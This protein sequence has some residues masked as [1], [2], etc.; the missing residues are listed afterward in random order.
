VVFVLYN[1]NLSE[2]CV[3]PLKMLFIGNSATYVND[4]PGTLVRLARRAGYSLEA[5][6]IVKG[7]ATLS[8][9]AD[10]DT[11]HGESVLRAIRGTYDIIW[12]QDNGNCV[13]CEEKRQDSLEACRVLGSLIRDAG[14][15][16]GI[17]LRPPYGYEKWGIS[18]FEQCKEY[19]LHFL[20][21]AEELQ[22]LNAFVNRAFAF[23]IRDTEYD[24]WG[25]DHA[26]TSSY[27]AY[28]AVCV[29]FA[30]IFHTSA[31]VLD[32]NDLPLEAASLLQDIA[33]KVVLAQDLPW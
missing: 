12:L 10:L 24:M 11:E 7:G 21:L 27:G 8:F 9:H 20:S 14:A 13:S 33:D 4:I 31:R 22:P 3:A 28:L 16:V 18:P 30:T 15:R 29:F 1:D 5:D 19:D 6:S 23:A 26:H 2:Q 25:A 17:Y 32:A